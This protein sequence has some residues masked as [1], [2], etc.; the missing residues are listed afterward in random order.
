MPRFGVFIVLSVAL[1]AQAP[2]VLD[3]RQQVITGGAATTELHTVTQPGL[4]PSTKLEQMPV[5]LSLDWL[6]LPTYRDGDRFVFHLTLRNVGKQSVRLPWEP[7]SQIVI[8]ERSV[9]A[10]S[11]ALVS[12][13]IDSPKGLLTIPIG[14][15]YGSN[16][17]DQTTKLLQPGAQAEIVAAGA[18]Q[19]L[20][21]SSNDLLRM[22]LE[23]TVNVLARIQFVTP[24]D[25]H[26]YSP[27][28]STNKLPIV[29]DR[30]NAH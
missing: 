7:N 20:G 17:P 2:D 9:P 12:I 23:P 21:Y 3:L 15:L 18:W 13:E 26:V 22:G 4:N 27:L 5:R 25:H 16:V 28:V 14:L 8:A 24:I 30:V 29:L 6:D 11:R 10:M 1:S 19:F